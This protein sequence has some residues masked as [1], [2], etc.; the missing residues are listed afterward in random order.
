LLI[1]LLAVH[2]CLSR[3]FRPCSLVSIDPLPHFTPLHSTFDA[4]AF[5]TPH[6][7][8]SRLRRVGGVNGVGN[9]LQFCG[10]CRSRPMTSRYATVKYV[11]AG[12]R[13]YALFFLTFCYC[14][15][16][17]TVQGACRLSPIQ[18][19]PPNA[20]KLH[21]FVGRRYAFILCSK[22]CGQMFMKFS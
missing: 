2:Y 19:T 14:F 22:T 10:R 18:C 9:S 20:M 3:I 17:Q 11:C 5:S 16:V 13:W 7:F 8:R 12:Q 6:F 15:I 21:S 1:R 4:P